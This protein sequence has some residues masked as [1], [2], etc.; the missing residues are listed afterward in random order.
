MVLGGM[1]YTFHSLLFMFMKKRAK[2][3]FYCEK[4]GCWMVQTEAE[5][6][7]AWR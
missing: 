5:D 2:R 7:R 1:E 6:V 4:L 3:D